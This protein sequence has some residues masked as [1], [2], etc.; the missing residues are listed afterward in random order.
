MGIEKTTIEKFVSL[1]Q[2]HPVIDV[3]SEGEYDHARI[4]G[5]YNM[6]LFDNEERK[7]VGTI[8]KQQSREAA[9][10]KGLVFFGPKMSAM[11][12]FVEDIKQKEQ[13]NHD[14]I[15]LVHC[16]RGGMRSAGVAWLLD[17]YG[18]KVY[19]LVGGYKAYRNWVL[20][21][22]KREWNFNILGGYTGSGKTIILESLKQ[23]GEAV[24]DLE[25]IAGHKGSAFGRIG[26]PPQESVEMFENKL[27]NELFFTAKKFP[28][29][30]IWLE[31]E[32]QRIGSVSIPHLLWNTIRAKRVYFIDVPF[33]QRLDYLK[34]TYGL[35]DKVELADAIKRIEKKLGG[36]ETK[37]SL[38]LLEQNDIR[39]CF[40]ILL[41]YY[42][43]LYRKS[44]EK[45]ENLTAL[46]VE[47]SSSTTDKDINAELIIKNTYDR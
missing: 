17:M 16:W 20:D 37:T 13:Y 36:L 38:E 2:Q 15:V 24:V 11:I 1:S 18:F 22:F 34:E 14:R 35:L 7:V 9:I 32:S 21:Q 25:G 12:S 19:T 4:P 45:R 40:S 43:K 8:Y 39:G 46:L 41:K 27:A 29:K 26:L 28:D 31:D 44:L 42:D 33:D 10:K 30:P 23:R 47:I 3:R 5:S 6:P